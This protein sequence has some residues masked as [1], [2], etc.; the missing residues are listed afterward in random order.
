MKICFLTNTMGI[1]SGYGRYSREVIS[2]V[3]K[4][5]K[6]IVLTEEKSDYPGEEAILDGAS[7]LR[8]IFKLSK[9]VKP[10]IENCDLIHALDV[11]PYGAIAALADKKIRKPLIINA[12]GTYS[13]ASFYD[14]SLQG[15]A[16]RYF[17]K[18]AYKKAD[19]VLSISNFVSTEILKK[20]K[21]KILETINL[22]VD[23][24]KFSKIEKIEH[25]GKV[26][27]SVG[28]IKKRK[29][30]HISIPAIAEVKKL[31]PDIRYKIAGQIASQEYFES[32]KKLVENNNLQS[33]VEFLS[34][35]SD[36]ELLG[37]YSTADLFLLPSV[38]IDHNFEG[39]GL[40]FLEAAAAGIPVIGT[41]GNGIEDAARDN[42][43]GFLIK[44]NNVQETSTAVAR[45]LADRI[46]YKQFSENGKIWAQKND[47]RY[48]VEKYAKVYENILNP[49][50]CK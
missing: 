37:Q 27:L 38:N 45:I 50:V 22:G 21:P 5:A 44:Q 23:F 9:L 33:N 42:F 39:F 49:T 25:A 19:E 10:Y 4:F 17:L 34:D 8:N 41:L 26:I 29:G 30:Y 40:V 11:F 12:V 35:I 31:I 15:L 6:V 32:L 16:R 48:V 43:N 7:S 2:R 1:N 13:I 36:E 28:I 20:V 3:S 18:L 46:L 14:N 47:W 24:N